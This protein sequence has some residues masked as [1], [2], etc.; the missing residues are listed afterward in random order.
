MALVHALERQQKISGLGLGRTDRFFACQGYCIPPLL[1]QSG[2][3][4]MGPSP[5]NTTLDTTFASWKKNRAIICPVGIVFSLFLLACTRRHAPSGLHPEACTTRFAPEG[6][7]Q[8]FASYKI[9]HQN[10]G[11]ARHSYSGIKSR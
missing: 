7:S 2:P 1:S 10:Q 6:M 3:C 11:K 5:L 8:E 4:S 9:V